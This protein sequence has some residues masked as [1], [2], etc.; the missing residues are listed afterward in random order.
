MKAYVTGAGGMI[1]SH[2]VEILHQKHF[3]VAG[4]FFHPTVDLNDID[5]T[6][7]EMFELDVRDHVGGRG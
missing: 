7:V 3:E 5:K 4:S 6:G 1:G 2:L